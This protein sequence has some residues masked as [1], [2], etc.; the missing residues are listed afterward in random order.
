[1][2]MRVGVS[3]LEQARAGEFDGAYRM[4]CKILG[5]VLGDPS[6]PK[7]RKLRTSNAKIANLLAT[8]GVRALLLGCGFEVQGEFLVLPESADLVAIRKG[9]R[10]LQEQHEHRATSEEGAKQKRLQEAAAKHEEQ[11]ARRQQMRQ[12]LD[13]DAAMRKEP[14]WQARAAGVKGGRNITTASD[15]GAVGKGG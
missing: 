14:G 10:K 2:K 7:F 9:L 3:M 4:L 1:M 6:E 11:E 12:G 13:D 5:N 15:I 8:Q